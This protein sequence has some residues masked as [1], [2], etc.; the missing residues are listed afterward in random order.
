MNNLMKK[1]S[2]V[3]F[4]LMFSCQLENDSRLNRQQ[5]SESAIDSKSKKL[6]VAEYDFYPISVNING[7]S[8]KIKELWAEKKWMYKDPKEHKSWVYRKTKTEDLIIEKQN[9]NQIVFV[10]NKSVDHRLGVSKNTQQKL[11]WCNACGYHTDK[12]VINVEEKELLEDT[13]KLYLFEDNHLDAENIP[14]RFIT[15]LTLIKK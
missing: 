13:I 10:F 2:F 12:L 14:N 6:L 5:E 7:N 9:G 15:E 1:I 4:L 11:E 3:I 8:Y